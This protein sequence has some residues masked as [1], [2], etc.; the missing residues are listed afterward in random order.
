MTVSLSSL[1]DVLAQDF[2]TICDLIRIH[3]RARPGSLALRDSVTTLTYAELDAAMDRVAAALQRDGLGVG[4]AI[5]VCA[6]SSAAYATVFLGALRAGLA[7]APLAPG[8][9][10]ASL[11]R[12]QQDAEARLLFVDAAAAQAFGPALAGEQRLFGA[13]GAVKELPG[14]F[15]VTVQLGDVIEIKTPGGGGFGSRSAS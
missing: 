10:S 12:M 11:R 3:A 6:A 4:D 14:C 2:G 7:V 5:A 8:S 9:T 1:Q 13:D 15:S